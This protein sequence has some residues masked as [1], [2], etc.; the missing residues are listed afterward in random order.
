VFH[1]V[2]PGLPFRQPETMQEMLADRLVLQRLQNLLFGTFAFLALLLAIA[3][4]YGL[5]SYEVELSTHEIGIRLALGASRTHV[6]TRMYRRVGTMLLVGV[7]AGSLIS[8]EAEKLLRSVL[9]VSTGGEFAVLV[10]L[11]TGLILVALA[12][13][14]IPARRAAKVDP[15]VALRYE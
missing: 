6:L 5:T 8:V 10:V 14:S 13:C 3:G 9:V 11:V 12:A 1:E 4:L 7:T 2:D 15:M